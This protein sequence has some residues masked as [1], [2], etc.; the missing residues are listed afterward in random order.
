MKLGEGL[1][2]V[3][4]N[5]RVDAVPALISVSRPGWRVTSMSHGAGAAAEL[6]LA[7]RRR[8]SARYLRV[9]T[10]LYRMGLNR[11]EVNSIG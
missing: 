1:L 6:R 8:Q 9:Q 2:S 3:C 10:G 5:S 4:K 7:R 11:G